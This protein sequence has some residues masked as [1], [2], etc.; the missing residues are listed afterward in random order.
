MKKIKVLTNQEANDLSYDQGCYPDFFPID[1]GNDFKLSDNPELF[2]QM[3][4]PRKICIEVTSYR[5]FCGGA[6]HYYAEIRADGID[7]CQRDDDGRLMRVGG[8]L[9]ENIKPF[10]E[11]SET[12]GVQNIL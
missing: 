1:I 5:G 4:N 10:Q 9:G 7:I 12:S 6:V 8:Y 11:I 3:P 2:V